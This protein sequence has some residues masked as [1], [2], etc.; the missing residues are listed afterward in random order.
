M[1]EL[2][3]CLGFSGPLSTSTITIHLEAVSLLQIDFFSSS[4]VLQLVSV[5]QP[6]AQYILSEVRHIWPAVCRRH[7]CPRQL[8]VS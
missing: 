5:V 3:P 4:T 2:G 7:A 6:E 8:S 1:G